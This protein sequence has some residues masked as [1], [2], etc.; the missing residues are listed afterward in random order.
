MARRPSNRA[1]AVLRAVVAGLLLAAFLGIGISL[2]RRPRAVANTRWSSLPHPAPLVADGDLAK[3]R[4]AARV[5]APEIMTHAPDTYDE[6]FTQN[7]CWRISRQVPGRTPAGPADPA[8]GDARDLRCLPAV[9]LSTHNTGI[10]SLIK[11]LA[12]HPNVVF[13][14]GSYGVW[15]ASWSFWSE[16][17]NTLEGYLEG[18][19]QGGATAK[20]LLVDPATNIIMDG[21]LST[22]SLYWAASG[23]VHTG[24]SGPAVACW[25]TC[26]DAHAGTP[27]YVTCMD[28]KCLPQG[29]TADHQ[30]ARAAGLAYADMQ[31]PMIMRALYGSRPPRLVIMVRDPIERMYSNYMGVKNVYERYG[32]TSHGFTLFVNE[33]LA[34]WRGCLDGTSER[35]LNGSAPGPERHTAEH[36]YLLFESL[37]QREEAVFYHCDQLFRG[38]YAPYLKIWLRWLPPSNVLVLKAEDYWRQPVQTMNRLLEFMSL[39]LLPPTLQDTAGGGKAAAG[40]FP[41]AGAARRL[42]RYISP[43]DAAA[44]MAAGPRQSQADPAGPMAPMA[45]QSLLQFYKPYNAELAELLGDPSILEWNQM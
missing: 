26:H 16:Y 15:G 41:A 12:A 9:Y 5:V 23:K 35:G 18:I 14:A 32:R 7:P 27:Q 22:F 37:S 3:L 25:K 44:V 29:R 42:P 38:L 1:W 43:E 28:Q 20:K 10:L 45:R 31:L 19:A 34:A 8:A 6:T 4:A 17:R 21:G 2:C 36:C 24:F 13:D 30:V 11:K 39:P 33:Q 40:T